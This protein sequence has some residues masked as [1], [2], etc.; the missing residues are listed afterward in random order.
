[1]ATQTEPIASVFEQ[2]FDNL[3]KAAES[4]IEMQQELFRKWGAAWPG[5]PQADNVWIDRMQKFQK[6]WT[7]T[8]TELTNKHRKMLDDEYRIA[9]DG[10]K[11][12]F[13]VAE[14]ADPQEYRQRCENLCRKSVELMREAG[15]LQMKETQEALNRWA[16]LAVKG[17]A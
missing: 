16:A 6:D 1:M 14:C 5:F 13:G 9:I 17:S 15:E 10:L 4:N 2:A 11:E 12:A 8:F 3:R 7:K